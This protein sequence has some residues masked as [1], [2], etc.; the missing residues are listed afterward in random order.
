M[1]AIVLMVG[2]CSSDGDESAPESGSPVKVGTVVGEVVLD[3]GED[4][5]A[6]RAGGDGPQR[7]RVEVAV[8]GHRDPLVGQYQTGGGCQILPTLRR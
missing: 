3:V 2:A 6:L 4:P 7:E 8:D 5:F 1:V